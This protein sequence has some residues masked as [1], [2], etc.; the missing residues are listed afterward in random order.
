MDKDLNFSITIDTIEPE[1]TSSFKTTIFNNTFLA[2]SANPYMCLLHVGLKGLA[3]IWYMFLYFFL[4]NFFLSS[5]MIL[6]VSIADFVVVQKYTGPRLVRLAWRVAVSKGGETE[7]SYDRLDGEVNKNDA[8]VFWSTTFATPAV[9]ALFLL[10]NILSF[11]LF[12]AVVST[13]CL[14]L[15][16]LNLLGYMK[17]Y[18]EYSPNAKSEFFAKAAAKAAHMAI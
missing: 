6:S 18:R 16:G 1:Q 14:G 12:W 7:W 4:G 8:W 2:D 9:W 5:L 3:L 17:C 13:A 11:S 10:V 15:T